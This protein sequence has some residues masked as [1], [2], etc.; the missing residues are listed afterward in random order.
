MRI[1]MIFLFFIPITGLGQGL[2]AGDSS[3]VKVTQPKLSAIY[4]TK[5]T[6]LFFLTKR[7]F[8]DQ[9]VCAANIVCYIKNDTPNRIVVNYTLDDGILSKEFWI[10]EGKL[11]FCYITEEYFDGYAKKAGWKNFKHLQ[12]YESRYYLDNEKIVYE[13]HHGVESLMTGE[14][15]SQLMREKERLLSYIQLRY[16]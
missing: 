10:D 3:I 7:S 12:A 13:K 9:P 5:D 2:M 8:I 16:K 11:I 4:D 1:K 14:I 6:T 15:N